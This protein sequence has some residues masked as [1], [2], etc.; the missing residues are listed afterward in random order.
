M[1]APV[2]VLA[3]SERQS[4]GRFIDGLGVDPQRRAYPVALPTGFAEAE[5]EHGFPDCRMIQRCPSRNI[6]QP[7]QIDTENSQEDAV[8]CY[9]RTRGRRRTNG[10]FYRCSGSTVPCKHIGHPATTQGER[11]QEMLAPDAGVSEVAS[12]CKRPPHK[13]VE[14]SVITTEHVSSPPL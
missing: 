13:V 14:L 2:P 10:F 5:R 9:P 8:S 7:V 4:K 6:Q 3:A 1:L 12:R 11:E